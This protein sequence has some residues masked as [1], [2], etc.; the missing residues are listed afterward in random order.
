MSAV[1][2]HLLAKSA[3]TGVGFSNNHLPVIFEFSYSRS[4]VENIPTNKSCKLFLI[5]LTSLKK[6]LLR[7]KHHS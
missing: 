2:S 1:W 4:I 5:F 7:R 6:M 3:E